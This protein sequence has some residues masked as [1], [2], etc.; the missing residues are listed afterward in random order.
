M[1]LNINLVNQDNSNSCGQVA[2]KVV[3]DYF[4]KEVSI[5]KLKELTYPDKS[6]V[7][8][9][10]GI[11]LGA[12]ELGFKGKLYSKVLGLDESNFELEYYRNNMDKLEEV[13]QKI[14]FFET[15]IFKFGGEMFEK[16]LSLDELLSKVDVNNLAIILIDWGVVDNRDKNFFHYVVISGYDESYVYVYDGSKEKQTHFPIKRDIFD[17]ARKI[18]GTDEDLIFIHKG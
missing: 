8:W 2:L 16:T 11:L 5:D 7:T 15:E 17:K 13:T 6:G 3:C 1:K 4:G 10:Q 12:L 18:K 9:S 14:D